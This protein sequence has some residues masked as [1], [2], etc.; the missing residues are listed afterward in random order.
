MNLDV[1]KTFCDLV[2][3][4]SFSKAAQINYVSQSAVS[5]QLAKLERD[6]QTQLINRGGGMV[7]P[8]EA[9]K[10]L[11]TGIKDILR[12][13]EG[14]QG[15]VRSAADSVR[16]VLRVGT[17][18]SVGLYQLDPYIRRFLGEHPEVN[19]RLEFEH[20][21]RIYSA[22]A[23]GEM[24]L[25]VVAYPEPQRSIEAIP[26]GVDQLVVVT[27]PGH[28]LAAWPSIEVAELEGEPFVAFSGDIPT[29]RSIDKLLRAVKV[30][31]NVRM[32]FDNIETIKRAVEIGSGVSILPL[33]TIQAE[34]RHGELSPCSSSAGQ[35]GPPAGHPPPPRQGPHPGQGQVPGYAQEAHLRS[36]Q[37]ADSSWRSAA[38]LATPP[39]VLRGPDF[40]Y[41]CHC[42]TCITVRLAVFAPRQKRRGGTR[43]DAQPSGL[44]RSGKAARTAGL[45]SLPSRMLTAEAWPASKAANLAAP[46]RASS[47]A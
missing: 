7:G 24:D 3:T 39:V 46:S 45:V 8:T 44:G 19:V 20:A 43:F 27:A 36:P 18:Y 5:Q 40:P 10:A 47:R 29:R 21:N 34:V 22:V 32:E 23:S 1:L 13:W 11:Y 28:R 12:R 41:G 17:I 38:R 14:L 37:P 33:Q 25:G 30:S 31:V 35:V 42:D 6:L 16:G 9:G 26:F 4:G 2:E 15:E